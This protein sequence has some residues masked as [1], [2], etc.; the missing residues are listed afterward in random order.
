MKFL[1]KMSVV[2]WSDGRWFQN[3]FRQ[4]IEIMTE[5]TFFSPRLEKTFFLLRRLRTPYFSSR[6]TANRSASCSRLVV[7]FQI[8]TS[9]LGWKTFQNLAESLLNCQESEESYLPKDLLLPPGLQKVWLELVSGKSS[10]SVPLESAMSLVWLI[11]SRLRAVVAPG[12]KKWPPSVS[13]S[14]GSSAVSYAGWAMM[15][16][17]LAK[18]FNE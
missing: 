2:P 3:W 6:W 5:K 15:W 16:T 13:S 17:L 11:F 14:S 18:P 4:Q 12:H 8:C 7:W 10:T 1:V 9:G